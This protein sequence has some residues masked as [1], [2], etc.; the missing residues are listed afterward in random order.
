MQYAYIIKLSAGNNAPNKQE[1]NEMKILSAERANELKSQGITHIASVVKSHYTTTYY[2]VNSIDNLLRNNGR[3]IAAPRGRYGNRI[4]VTG[5]Q[6]DW[7]HTI[8]ATQM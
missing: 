7:S 3:W 8:P 5:A 6:V 2:N 1:E 4:G